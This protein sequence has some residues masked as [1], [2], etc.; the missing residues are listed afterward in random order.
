MD[1]SFRSFVHQ[2]M[3]VA[4][5]DGIAV[6]TMKP[7]GDGILLQSKT[8]TPTE[9]L[10]YALSQPTSV[11]IHGMEKPEYLDHALEVVK[12]FKPLSNAQIEALTAKAKPAAMTGKYEK[13][14]TGNQFDSTA[15]HPEWLG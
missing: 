4:L 11:V 14:K 2:V 12:N 9:C 13:F 6:Q 7:M 1:W 5:K 15:K 8:V 10:Q 3:P